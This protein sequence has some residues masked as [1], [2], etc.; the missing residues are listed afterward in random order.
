[1][2]RD[3]PDLAG[4]Q[5]IRSRARPLFDAIRENENWREHAPFTPEPGG[6]RSLGRARRV[7]ERSTIFDRGAP[8]ATP[9]LRPAGGP[10]RLPG[11][12]RAVRLAGS[13]GSGDRN[14]A[15]TTVP[16]GLGRW[17][18]SPG[19]DPRHSGGAR[20]AELP[21]PRDRALLLR[22]ARGPER[23]GPVAPCMTSR[24]TGILGRRSA[25]GTW[26]WSASCRP[27]SPV[28][29]ARRLARCRGRSPTPAGWRGPGSTAA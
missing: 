3:H 9:G 25:I 27:A 29:T 12:S 5:A 22:P 6:A 23:R 11:L 7:H 15:R 20:R 2:G 26:P 4:I 18:R 28:T 21:A 1:M 17:R 13:R 16:P 19:R 24:P 10:A 14:R 8:A